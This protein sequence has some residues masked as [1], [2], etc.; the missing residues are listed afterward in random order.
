[1]TD[2]VW[3]EIQREKHRKERARLKVGDRVALVC[4][5]DRVL[6]GTVKKVPPQRV[7]V[8]VKKWIT[9]YRIQDGRQLE[10]IPTAWL[11][12]LATPK[13]LDAL[14]NPIAPKHTRW[15]LERVTLA[16]Q[17]SGAR[18]IDLVENLS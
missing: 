8:A 11:R 15:T 1:M 5:G 17:Y 18:Q 13:E 16:S 3:E 7:S 6:V 9:E 4:Q 10:D 14:E 2:S 12:G